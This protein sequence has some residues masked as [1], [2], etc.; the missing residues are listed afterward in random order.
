MRSLC[1]GCVGEQGVRAAAAGAH[2][3][4]AVCDGAVFAWGANSA[5]QLGTRTFRDKAAPTPVRDL[6]GRGVCQAACGLEH[7]LFLCRCAP[8]WAPLVSVPA[9][10]H[11]WTLPGFCLSTAGGLP[12][13]DMLELLEGG[14][15]HHLR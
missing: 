2:H 1:A 13:Q 4:V 11:P 5:G 9:R 7:T 15:V 8:P 6:D 12:P 3:T 14:V 10:W